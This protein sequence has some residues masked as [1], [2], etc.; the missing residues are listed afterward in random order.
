MKITIESTDKLTNYDGTPVRVW[1]GVTAGGAKC[2]VFVRALAVHKTQNASEFERELKRD[3][4]PGR[5][6]PPRHIL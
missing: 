2:Y 3:L 4:P 1:E 6:I 5:A